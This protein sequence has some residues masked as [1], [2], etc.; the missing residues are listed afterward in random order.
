MKPSKVRTNGDNGWEF[1]LDDN[2]VHRADGPA[3]IFDDGDWSW[4]LHNHLHR[5]YGIAISKKKQKEWFIHG[6][7][8][9]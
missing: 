1:V 7:P 2:Y 6:R 3:L 4:W 5:Y 8:I 9:K